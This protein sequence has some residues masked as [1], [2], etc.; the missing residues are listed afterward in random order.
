M[1]DDDYYYPRIYPWERVQGG[2]TGCK[3]VALTCTASSILAPRTMKFT[4]AIPLTAVALMGQTH[5]AYEPKVSYR[6]C[7][8]CGREAFDGD[9]LTCGCDPGPLMII[10][11]VKVAGEMQ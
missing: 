3:P 8:R 5:S 6:I 11:S 4:I 2:P 7:T 10:T 9:E 1:E